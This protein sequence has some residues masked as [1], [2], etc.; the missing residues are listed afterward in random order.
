MFP[1]LPVSQ[2]SSLNPQLDKA[3]MRW[4]VAIFT[5]S[6]IKNNVKESEIGQTVKLANICYKAYY[7]ILF[8][9]HS[10]TNNIFH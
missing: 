10:P 1:N 4:A 5:L 3:A 6:L 9:K 2:L 8:C 7:P